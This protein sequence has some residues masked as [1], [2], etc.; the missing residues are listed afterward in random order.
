MIQ[1]E[2]VKATLQYKFMKELFDSQISKEDEVY[3]N[4]FDDRPEWMKEMDGVKFNENMNWFDEPKEDGLGS[5][6]R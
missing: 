2:F 3:Y 5:R 4:A 1:L 6:L